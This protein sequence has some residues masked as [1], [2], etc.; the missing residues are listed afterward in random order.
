MPL[1]GDGAP[2]SPPL[3]SSSRGASCCRR[4]SVKVGEVGEAKKPTAAESRLALEQAGSRAAA[5]GGAFSEGSW[6]T[7]DRSLMAP[8][9]GVWNGFQG[10][11][12]WGV[13]PFL[14]LGSQ[15]V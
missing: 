2:Q 14:T 3:G 5:G 1:S 8:S 12:F 15:K 4:D 10:C 7:F 11:I 9:I 6:L 13:K